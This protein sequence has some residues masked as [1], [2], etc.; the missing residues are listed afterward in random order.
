MRALLLCLV[1]LMTASSDLAFAEL[2]LSTKP[3]P[4]ASEGRTAL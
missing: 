3:A 4:G 1:G 2:K